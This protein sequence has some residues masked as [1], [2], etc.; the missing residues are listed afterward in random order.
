M[1]IQVPGCS[2][3]QVTPAFL[4][5]RVSHG[6]P[7]ASA[8][9]HVPTAQLLA[10]FPFS[11]CLQES[12]RFPLLLVHHLHVAR[13][14]STH[15]DSLAIISRCAQGGG[16]GVFFFLQIIPCSWANGAAR[17]Q[18]FFYESYW[19]TVLLVQTRIPNRHVQKEIQHR[20]VCNMLP[21]AWTASHEMHD[22]RCQVGFIL[23]YNSAQPTAGM[24]P[25][26]LSRRLR[27]VSLYVRLK[28]PGHINTLI[29]TACSLVAWRRGK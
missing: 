11:A 14:P 4:Y 29:H 27:N 25:R 5:C 22:N 10:M 19:G 18:L 15:R 16:R 17:F 24:H 28:H 20:S 13:T 8:E 2:G 23:S 21:A 7:V 12:F 3:C 1:A 9:A 6:G 26:A